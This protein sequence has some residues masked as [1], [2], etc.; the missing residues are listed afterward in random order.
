MLNLSPKWYLDVGGTIRD[1][2]VTPNGEYIVAG[3]G[4]NTVYFLNGSWSFI[5]FKPE[6]SINGFNIL[7]V[8]GLLGLISVIFVKKKSKVLL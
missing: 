8:C 5:S 6:L 2:D 7:L 3:N 4:D 1:V